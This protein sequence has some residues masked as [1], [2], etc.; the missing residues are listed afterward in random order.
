MKICLRVAAVLF[1]LCGAGLILV[2]GD[3]DAA[4]VRERQAYDV[5]PPEVPTALVPPCPSCSPPRKNIT[6]RWLSRCASLT[7]QWREVPRSDLSVLCSSPSC[8]WVAKASAGT[9][10]GTCEFLCTQRSEVRPAVLKESRLFSSAALY[11]SNDDECN[12][13]FRFVHPASC[14]KASGASL[15]FL[16][17]SHTR[18]IAS[19]LC[20][21]LNSSA[22]DPLRDQFRNITAI[23]RSSLPFSHRADHRADGSILTFAQSNYG[24]QRRVRELQGVASDRKG[25]FTH[26]VL[27]RG[28]W[29]LLFFDRSPSEI[30]DD[31]Y[32]SLIAAVQ[33]WPSATFILHLPHFCHYVL[34]KDKRRSK[35]SVVLRAQWRRRCFSPERI[36]MIRSV[37]IC[38]A[39]RAQRSYALQRIRP[40]FEFLKFDTFKETRNGFA[41]RYVDE[42]GHH[43]QDL[44]LES[45]TMKFLRLFLC[46][47]QTQGDADQASLAVTEVEGFESCALVERFT[48]AYVPDLECSCHHPLRASPAICKKYG[49]SIPDSSRRH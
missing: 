34:P 48:T 14:F 46:P 5:G 13:A 1:L 18:Y 20:M 16:G 26:I 40:G 30:T 2:L 12:N 44:V 9:S 39:Y 38:A 6:T 42:L 41:K 17:H 4:D 19:M 45:L 49:R 35:P 21:M 10:A 37:N 3:Q 25:G 24:F 27:S 8:S 31:L 7:Y 28:S 23:H 29:D 36:R 11:L 43:Y 33:A 22:C 15:L 32:S 47:S